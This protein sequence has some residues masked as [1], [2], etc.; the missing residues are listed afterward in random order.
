MAAQLR[1]VGLWGAEGD[2]ASPEA[3]QI[4]GHPES[5]VEIFDGD[6]DDSIEP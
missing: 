1:L 3:D 4:L 5:V 6:Y 2:I